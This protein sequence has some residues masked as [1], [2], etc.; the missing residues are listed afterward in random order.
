[1]NILDMMMEKRIFANG[2][3][4]KPVNEL[5]WEQQMTS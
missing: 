5:T 2:K 3:L 4:I 1:M